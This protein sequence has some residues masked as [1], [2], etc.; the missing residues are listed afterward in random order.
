MPVYQ[1]DVMLCPEALGAY[2]T[3]DTKHIRE[4]FDVGYQDAITHMDAIESVLASSV[5]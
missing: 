2:P 5:R 3:F 1:C 4:I